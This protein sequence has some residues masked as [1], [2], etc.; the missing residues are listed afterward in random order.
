MRNALRLD[1]CIEASI[2]SLLDCCDEVVCVDASSTDGT[3]E[4]IAKYQSNPKFKLITS[5]EWD[6]KIFYENLERCANIAR[7]A[8]KTKWH[9]CL[10]ADE[11]INENDISLIR[12]AINSGKSDCYTFNRLNFWGTPDFFI[13]LYHPSAPVGSKVHR[14]GLSCYPV[15][16]QSDTAIRSP[17]GSTQTDIRIFHYGFLRDKKKHLEKIIECTTAATGKPDERI[18]RQK[19]EKGEFDPWEFYSRAELTPF[20]G[21]HPKYVYNWLRERYDME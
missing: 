5:V 9:L 6:T 17:N 3:V 12:E 20:E 1:Y 21:H 10:E 15:D 8:L 11:V 13:P 4:R 19:K 2:E 14:L 7:N 18:V 16:E